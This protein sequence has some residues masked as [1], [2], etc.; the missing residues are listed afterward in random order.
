MIK[1]SKVGEGTYGVVY[2]AKS[3][4]NP[5]NKLA[6]KRNIIDITTNFSGSIKE[7]DILSKLKGHPF[8]VNLIDVTFNSPFTS[9][10]SP[11]KVNKRYYKDDYMYFVFEKAK[12]DLISVLSDKS[13]HM[14]YLK[15]S[16]VQMFL[17]LEY[18]H[19]K[20]IIHRDIKP[21][22]LLWFVDNDNNTTIK[23]CDF[24]M[25]KS[26]IKSNDNSP[27]VV[28]CWYRAPEICFNNS[29]YDTKSDIWSL[30]CILY[31]MVKKCPLLHGCN[32]LNHELINRILDILPD[33][34]LKDLSEISNGSKTKFNLK[35]RLSLFQLFN[36]SQI[37]IKN[38]NEFPIN[39]AK[40]DDFI[41]LLS[42]LLVLNPKKR[43]SATEALN[44]KYF[45]PYSHIIAEVRQKYLNIVPIPQKFIF[46]DCNERLW[47]ND[48]V[49]KIYNMKSTLPWCTHRILFQ[50]VNIFYRYLNYLYLNNNSSSSDNIKSEYVGRYLNEQQTQLRYFLCLYM[51]I[52]Y[53]TSSEIPISFNDLPSNKFTSPKFLKEA[54]QFEIELIRDILLFNI[55]NDTPYDIAYNL[56]INL[57]INEKSELFF[58]YLKYPNYTDITSK[59]I[60]DDFLS[61]SNNKNIVPINPKI[62]IRSNPNLNI[63]N[64]TNININ[65]NNKPLLNINNNKLSLNLVNKSSLNSNNKPIL[66]LNIRQLS[67]QPRSI[68]N[69]NNNKLNIL[70]PKLLNNSNLNININNQN[71]L[72][73]NNKFQPQLPN[74]NISVNKNNNS[75][76]PK[77]N[78]MKKPVLTIKSKNN[79]NKNN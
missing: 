21:G 70:Q 69:N 36:L 34:N 42:H 14:G 19:S 56:N 44:H 62:H 53:F 39:G 18:I 26:Y 6:V 49:F 64:N 51:A 50:S 79:L 13:V 22:N 1:I 37:Q 54:E 20:N 46:F 3:L 11:L 35:Q 66:N 60:F 48:I 25:A 45:E 9:P 52:K 75:Q 68:S 24:G 63:N 10:C 2:E 65:N 67:Q 38:F 73:T 33:L 78:V 59:Q 32:D 41:D 5:N 43:Y 40:Y 30:G 23:F 4:K 72:S 61:Q 29:N 12:C 27:N 58:F 76:L 74:I 28:T 31:E 77:N 55:Y 8:I 47:M 15:L 17:G 7:L 57:T 71:K 16:M